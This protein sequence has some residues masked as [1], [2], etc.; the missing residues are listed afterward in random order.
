LACRAGA[1]W[2]GSGSTAAGDTSVS[3]PSRRWP[4]FCCCCC[5]P[6]AVA[7]SDA[8]WSSCEGAG[9]YHTVALY[10]RSIRKRSAPARSY[11]HSM[12]NHTM[13]THTALR[14]EPFTQMDTVKT[15]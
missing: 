7:W 3:L 14:V 6:A 4:G 15:P 9:L 13:R 5:C 1:L 11:L 2:C 10:C 12:W 8:A